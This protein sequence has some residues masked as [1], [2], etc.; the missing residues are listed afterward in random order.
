MLIYAVAD[1][2]GR[3]DRL[4]TIR[5][6]IE[7]C[8]PDI[9]VLAGDVTGHKNSLPFINQINALPVPVL[10]IRGN[11]DRKK[12]KKEGKRLNARFPNPMT[13]LPREVVPGGRTTVPRRRRSASRS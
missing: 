8:H 4:Q 12:E 9:V 11:S 7:T 5:H 2:H 6:T 13:P 3:A 10:A 1:I